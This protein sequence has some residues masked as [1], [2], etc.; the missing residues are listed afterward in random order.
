MGFT[1]NTNEKGRQSSNRIEFISSLSLRPPSITSI[2]RAKPLRYDT[3]VIS[4]D[5]KLVIA[6]KP[7]EKKLLNFI[8]VYKKKK[9]NNND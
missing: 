1:G 8:R 3:R 9:K 2:G 7:N 6:A 5:R 4:A